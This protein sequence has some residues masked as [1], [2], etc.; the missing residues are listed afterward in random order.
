M[1]DLSQFIDKK[2]RVTFGNNDVRD[3]EVKFTPGGRHTFPYKLSWVGVKERYFTRKGCP[4]EWPRFPE[5]DI[6]HI[7]EIKPMKKYEQLEKQVV[8]LQKEIDRLKREEK[9]YPKLKTVKITRTVIFTPED[10]FEHCE[11]WD[12]E[13]TESGYVEYYSDTDSLRDNFECEE[14]YTQEITVMEN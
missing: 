9:N 1:I 10:Y 14:C 3:V 4:S 8:E 6:I 5:L 12:E 11:E 2:V 7:E 13:P